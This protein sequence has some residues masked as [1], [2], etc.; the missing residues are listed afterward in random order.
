MSQR[1]P[2]S[3]AGAQGS[4]R[5][6]RES[7]ERFGLRKLRHFAGDRGHWGDL[8]VLA[9]PIPVVDVQLLSG[10][11]THPEPGATVTQGKSET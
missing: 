8:C 10:A 4:R 9:L 7:G 11:E 6:G 1:W 5:D 3:F 2:F